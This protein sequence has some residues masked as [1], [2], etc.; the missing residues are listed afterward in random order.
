[1]NIPTDCCYTLNLKLNIDIA[2]EIIYFTF[3]PYDYVI[4]TVK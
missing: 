4:Q 3:N 1:M 2:N